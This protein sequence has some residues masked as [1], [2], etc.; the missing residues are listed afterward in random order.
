MWGGYVRWSCAALAGLI[1]VSLRVVCLRIV[2]D[3]RKRFKCNT[4]A[5]WCGHL[6][7]LLAVLGAAHTDVARAFQTA[8]RRRDIP[9]LLYAA[10][11]VAERIVALD[12]GDAG[13]GTPASRGHDAGSPSDRRGAASSTS[14]LF[15]RFSDLTCVLWLE[16]DCRMKSGRAMDG[17]RVLRAFVWLAWALAN[18][19][20]ASVAK[21]HRCCLS[22]VCPG[23]EA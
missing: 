3:M 18:W 6:V 13:L 22:V 14:K 21:P 19:W 7:L 16:G 4:K 17:A 10:R 5:S 8:G 15:D 23:I 12:V 20:A 11:I 9:R 1:D 2:D